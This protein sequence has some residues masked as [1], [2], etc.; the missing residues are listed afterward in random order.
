MDQLLYVVEINYYNKVYLPK[1][2]Y[3]HMTFIQV[4]LM[5]LTNFLQI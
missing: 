4:H 1:G 2:F 3:L 5:N